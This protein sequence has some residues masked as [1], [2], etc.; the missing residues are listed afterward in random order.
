MTQEEE[1]TILAREYAE[2]VHEATSEPFKDD[3]I[4]EEVE[5]AEDVIRFL[6]SRYC[7]IEKGKVEK[8]YHAAKELLNKIP[9]LSSVWSA[10]IGQINIL[11]SLFPEI[12]KEMEG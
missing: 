4:C 12:V 9:V 7:L 11:E 5:N 8:E 1:I 10:I 3:V 2:E 6:L